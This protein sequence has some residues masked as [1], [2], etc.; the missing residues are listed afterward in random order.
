MFLGEV[1]STVKDVGGAI[2]SSLPALRVCCDSSGGWFFSM[3]AFCSADF[4][5]MWESRFSHVGKRL[6]VRAFSASGRKSPWVAEARKED[7]KLFLCHF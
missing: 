6:S 4:T 1:Q 2:P 7:I 5:G 3:L